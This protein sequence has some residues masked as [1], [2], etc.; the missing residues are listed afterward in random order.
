MGDEVYQC[1][2]C[3]PDAVI[4][5][6]VEERGKFSDSISQTI[7]ESSNILR[8]A[9]ATK[10]QMP[11]GTGDFIKSV[12]FDIS[13]PSA[14]DVIDHQ[15]RLS[16]ARPGNSPCEVP[17][18]TIPYG[19]H[20]IEACIFAWA[21]DTDWFCKADLA[22]KF[23]R[24]KQISQIKNIFTGWAKGIWNNWVWRAYQ[25]S[26]QNYVLNANIPN[27]HGAAG[28]PLA[29]PTSILTLYWLDHITIRLRDASGLVGSPVKGSWVILIGEEECKT[30][31][32]AYFKDGAENYGVR[33]NRK[34]EDYKRHDMGLFG[35]MEYY[36]LSNYKF[37]VECRAPRYRDRNGAETWDDALVEDVIQVAAQNGTESQINPD[38]RD[39]T[40]AKYVETLIFNVDAV[41][42]LTPPM[43]LTENNQFHQDRHPGYSYAGMFI[44]VRKTEEQDPMGKLIKY[45]SEYVAG[46]ESVFPKKGASILSLACH[47]SPALETISYT[48]TP[49]AQG[50][51]PTYIQEYIPINPTGTLQITTKEALPQAA[52]GYRLFLVTRG[53][54]KVQ[55]ETVDTYYCEAMGYWISSL[56]FTTADAGACVPR[57][58]DQWKKV[59]VF[60]EG[61]AED[62]LVDEAG[63]V[64]CSGT[65]ETTAAS[66]VT[67]SYYGDNIR[68]VTI[69]T[70]D[71]EGTEGDIEALETAVQAHLDGL[72]DGGTVSIT[73]TDDLWVITLTDSSVTEFSV[74]AEAD[75]GGLVT[76]Y[77]DG[78]QVGPQTVFTVYDNESVGG[79]A[80][81]A[82]EYYDSGEN[83]TVGGFPI[84]TNGTEFAANGNAAWDGA[85]MV[86]YDTLA[87]AQAQ[88]NPVYDSDDVG[89][90]QVAV[91]GGGAVTGTQGG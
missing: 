74:Y 48:L 20:T 39:P 50:E 31:F 28:Y 16:S 1:K 38:Y 86:Y 58:C 51:D 89:N 59:S 75:G 10:K 82:G 14:R 4:T 6:M 35:G 90:S 30:L 8:F 77:S 76:H 29:N 19:S 61:T 36:E 56:T 53:D 2:D 23:K 5:Q 63:C 40:V 54:R 78:D 68:G 81:Y 15:K 55:I 46:M 87:H 18:K 25:R 12:V 66:T 64:I 57:D 72:T 73:E 80:T 85:V 52:D 26:V 3:D 7:Q 37:F 43:G 65:A 21:W 84:W 69:G 11:S 27:Q 45:Y 67:V 9:E 88:S 71:I 47:T 44:P 49:T 41:N 13:I 32:D 22:F 34:M 79:F 60:A 42:W 62:A 83:T 70:T 33:M 91:Q 17:V 24:E